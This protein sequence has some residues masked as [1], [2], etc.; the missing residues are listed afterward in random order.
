[1]I[2]LKKKQLLRPEVDAST[3]ALFTVPLLV[4]KLIYVEAFSSPLKRRK[5][6]AKQW[7]AGTGISGTAATCPFI[8]T[9]SASTLISVITVKKWTRRCADIRPRKIAKGRSAGLRVC[10][11]GRQP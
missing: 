8:A 2:S 3:L 1:M 4:L 6:V 7:G 5:Q 10:L 9:L 11:I